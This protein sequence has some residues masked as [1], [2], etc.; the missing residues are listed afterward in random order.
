MRNGL[1]RPLL[2]ISAVKFARIAI[3]TLIL[4]NG[5]SYV[6]RSIRYVHDFL[7][8]VLKGSVERLN[9]PTLE[10]SMAD[11]SSCPDVKHSLLLCPK[12]SSRPSWRSG[13]KET[14]QMQMHGR[15]QSVVGQ[16]YTS[17]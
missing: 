6:R 7:G 14:G 12:A 8:S 11:M 4:L 1:W 2:E 10:N 13:G 3:S 5:L 16:R 17:P 9:L 15:M